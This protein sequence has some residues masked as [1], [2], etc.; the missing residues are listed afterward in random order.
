MHHDSVEHA[1]QQAVLKLPK[2][3]RVFQAQKWGSIEQDS[4]LFGVPQTELF[5]WQTLYQI[6]AHSNSFFFLMGADSVDLI[7]PF[8]RSHIPNQVQQLTIGTS[9]FPLSHSLDYR[10]IVS[11]LS[12]REWPNLKSLGL[13]LCM[14]FHN[15]GDA[16]GMLGDITA[17]LKAAPNLEQLWVSGYFELTQPVSLPHLTQ[18]N[19]EVISAL[20]VGP[21]ALTQNSV[22]QLFNS[23]FPSL[24]EAYID[25]SFPDM[26][27]EYKLPEHFTNAEHWRSLSRLEVVGLFTKGTH[28]KLNASWSALHPTGKFFFDEVQELD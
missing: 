23:N 18:L 27:S 2:E 28:A 6:P 7:E 5:N 4:C 9:T 12:Q 15:A 25:V 21:K 10:K 16:V 8:V 22:D 26:L 1:F 13:G 14:L 20:G 19:I 3:Q 11:L 17:L 24:E